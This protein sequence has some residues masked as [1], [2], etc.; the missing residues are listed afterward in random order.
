[1]VLLECHL[2]H[3]ALLDHISNVAPDTLYP[4]LLCTCLLIL[5][6]LTLSPFS[7]FPCLFI[8]SLP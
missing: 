4:I 7:L 5:K 2:L 3:E 8:M 1:M 6:T